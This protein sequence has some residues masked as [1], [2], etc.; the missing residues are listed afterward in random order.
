MSGIRS[1]CAALLFGAVSAIAATPPAGEIAA[2]LDVH[3]KLFPQGEYVAV[4][5]DLVNGNAKSAVIFGDADFVLIDKA[6]VAQTTEPLHPLLMLRAQRAL[7]EATH[8]TYYQGFHTIENTVHAGNPDHFVGIFKK[9]DFVGGKLTLRYYTPDSTNDT[10]I[11]KT[12]K[13]N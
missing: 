11:V 9:G 2:S 10:P 5:V 12:F 6:G 13:L 4:A 8:G 1:V 7:F 3:V